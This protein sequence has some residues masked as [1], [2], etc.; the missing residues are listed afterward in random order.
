MPCGGDVLRLDGRDHLGEDGHRVGAVQA[1]AEHLD[2]RAVVAAHDRQR[3]GVAVEEQQ[4]GAV[5]A[6]RPAG[7]LGQRARG[8]QFGDQDDVVD[9]AGGKRVAQCGGLGVVTST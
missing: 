6:D 7:G 2:D 8:V 3:G 1:A 9:A 4:A 5:V